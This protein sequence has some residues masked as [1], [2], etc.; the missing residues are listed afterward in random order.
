MMNRSLT[1]AASRSI[2]L[3]RMIETT[4]LLLDAFCCPNLL[5]SN[6]T[7]LSVQI[8]VKMAFS[9][10]RNRRNDD[11]PRIFQPRLQWV[12]CT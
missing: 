5:I 12:N 7:T 3:H 8:G 10:F 2:V 11:N 9:E 6:F 1:G 4:K